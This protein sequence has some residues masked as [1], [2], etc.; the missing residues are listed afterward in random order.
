[1]SDE[2][3]AKPKVTILPA[4]R[5]KGAFSAEDWS[6][7]RSGLAGKTELLDASADIGRSG[8]R[9]FAAPWLAA[10]KPTRPR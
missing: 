8:W 4:R 10:S 1:M 7:K 6:L 2:T 9:T 3:P 5:A